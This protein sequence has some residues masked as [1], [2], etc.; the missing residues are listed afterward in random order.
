M[1]DSATIDL[2]A[3]QTVIDGEARDGLAVYG[4]N[5]SDIDIPQ[6][7]TIDESFVQTTIGQLHMRVIALVSHQQALLQACELFKVQV[8]SQKEEIAALR[9]ENEKLRNGTPEAEG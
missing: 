3:P 9:A 4:M 2:T 8:R 7:G 6:F 5:E 1:P